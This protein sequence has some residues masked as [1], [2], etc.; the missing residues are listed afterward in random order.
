MFNDQSLEVIKG[1]QIRIDLELHNQSKRIT[2][3]SHSIMSIIYRQQKL[4]DVSR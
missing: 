1:S 2:T 3:N 4:K